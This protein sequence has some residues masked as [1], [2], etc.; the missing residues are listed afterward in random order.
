M[1]QKFLG[2]MFEEFL[3]MKL[4]KYLLELYHYSLGTFGAIL[5]KLLR[6]F[7][8]DPGGIVNGILEALGR[9]VWVISRKKTCV[10]VS[11]ESPHISR[12]FRKIY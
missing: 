8:K 11:E 7:L 10:M 2:K 1:L 9:T 4:L 3:T 12:N 6:K 5:G